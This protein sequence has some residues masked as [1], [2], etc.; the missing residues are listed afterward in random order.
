MC[1]ICPKLL[2]SGHLQS[3][4]GGQ[5]VKQCLTPIRLQPFWLLDSGK[6]AVCSIHVYRKPVCISIFNIISKFTTH[7]SVLLPPSN[8][9]CFFFS[10]SHPASLT[11]LALNYQKQLHVLSSLGPSPDKPQLIKKTNTDQITRIQETILYQ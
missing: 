9:P 5:R 6:T 2:N 10:S 3:N 7:I 11:L 8:I 1:F 4:L